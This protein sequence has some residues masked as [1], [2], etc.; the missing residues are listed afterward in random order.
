[1]R[2]LCMH[3]NRNSGRRIRTKQE[4]PR[5]GFKTA[6]LPPPPN[7]YSRQKKRKLEAL[8]E[9]VVISLIQEQGGHALPPRHWVKT[10]Q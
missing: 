6:I 4:R 7:Q 5:D 10:S 3:T 9:A 8:S 2:S 1:M